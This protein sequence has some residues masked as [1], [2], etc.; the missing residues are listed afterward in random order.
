MK[1]MTITLGHRNYPITTSSELLNH[2]DS[3]EL[4]KKG[5]QDMLVTNQT[6]SPLYLSLIQT[7][8]EQGGVRFDHIILPD[9]GKYKSLSSIELIFNELLKK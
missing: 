1:K 2:F 7:V 6:L 8:L 3:F 4:L 5:D 9:S